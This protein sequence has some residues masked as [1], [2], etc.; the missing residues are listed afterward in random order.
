M[1]ISQHWNVLFLNTI[2][3]YIVNRIPFII[4]VDLARVVDNNNLNQYIFGMDSIAV[5]KMDNEVFTTCD[6]FDRIIFMKV[7]INGILVD[8]MLDGSEVIIF[9]DINSEPLLIKPNA[10]YNYVETNS[11]NP[12]NSNTKYKITMMDGK[13]KTF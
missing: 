13:S 8:I 11:S 4:S 5:I 7:H 1:N 3:T 9:K 6:I 12:T 2:I 10:Y